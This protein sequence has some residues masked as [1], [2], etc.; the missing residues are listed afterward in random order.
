MSTTAAVREGCA[1]AHAFMC[2]S[3]PV[4]AGP[5]GVKAA[6][7]C[8]ANVPM[9]PAAFSGIVPISIAGIA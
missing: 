4:S 3:A 1:V 7:A 5:V 8:A 9:I 6:G 2:W